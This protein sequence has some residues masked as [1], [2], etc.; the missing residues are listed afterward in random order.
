MLCVVVLD[1]QLGN[2]PLRSPVLVFRTLGVCLIYIP[3]MYVPFLQDALSISPTVS[4][5]WMVAIVV[6]VL[7]VPA[8]KLVKWCWVRRFDQGRERELYSFRQKRNDDENEKKRPFKARKP[9][10]YGCDRIQPGRIEFR[11]LSLRKSRS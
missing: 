9:R 6:S 4:S 7:I 8:V 11:S 5:S 2:A 1:R 3:T 10:G